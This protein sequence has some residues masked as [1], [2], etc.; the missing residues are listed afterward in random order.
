[1]NNYVVVQLYESP[2]Y[3]FLSYIPF[4][5][6]FSPACFAEDFFREFFEIEISVFFF[7]Y[8]VAVYHVIE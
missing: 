1:M 7:Y 2:V 5:P 4:S 8:C 3:P 6:C